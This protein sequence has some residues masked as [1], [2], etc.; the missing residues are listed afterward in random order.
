MSFVVGGSIGNQNVDRWAY[1]S[2][3][4]VPLHGLRL[5]YWRHAMQQGDGRALVGTAA[6]VHYSINIALFAVDW[7]SM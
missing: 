7:P 3:S 2:C 1:T 4:V 6:I 5:H